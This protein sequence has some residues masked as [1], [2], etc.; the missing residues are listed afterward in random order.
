LQQAGYIFTEGNR[1]AFDLAFAPNGDLFATDNGPD[2]DMSESLYW[3]RPGL[4]YGFPWHI[5]GAD[6]PQQFP[7]Y[8]PSTD[9][10]LDSRFIAV[11]SGYYHNDLTFPPAPTNFADSVI[12]LGPDADSYRDPADGSIKDASSLGQMV[13]TFTAHRSPLGLVFDTVGAMADPFQNHGFVLSWTQGDP[14]GNT[15]A[16]PFK[17]ASQDMLDLN[18]TKLGSTNY[19]STTTRIVGGFS[20]PIDAEII[21]NRIYAIE[22]GGNQGIWEITFPP[23]SPTIIL[24]APA[25]DPSGAFEF[26][27]IATPGLN[28][29]ID[30]SSNLLS[31]SSVTN[32]IPTSSP[33]QFSDPVV[34]D[35]TRFYRLVQH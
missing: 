4:H 21:G 9:K 19:Q 30:T 29:E 27:V 18:L 2:R 8:D 5:G 31:W 34:T 20:N 11:Q 24:S 6:N 12:N 14:T 32:F 13:S 22:Y 26:N 7:T 15:V 33:F 1:N 3:L 28:Y 35:S 17:D 25:V 10:L 16:G 23:A